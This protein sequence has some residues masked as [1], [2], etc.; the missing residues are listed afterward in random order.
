MTTTTLLESVLTPEVRAKLASGKVTLTELTK[1]VAHPEVFEVAT[2]PPLPAVISPAQRDALH[3]LELIYGS[4]CPAEVREL[5]TDE[6]DQLMDERL[7]ID[8]IATLVESRKSD[9]RTIVLNHVDAEN[10]DDEATPRDKEG[11]I[12]KASKTQPTQQKKVFSWE[13]SNRGG[14]IDVAALKE[15]D[16]S[17]ELAHEDYLAMTEQIRVVNE[18]RVL[19]L[20]KKKPELLDTLAKAVSKTSQ[21][22][23]LYV[24]KA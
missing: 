9:I 23:S 17:G 15:L 1:F 13:V 2:G 21:V 12:L 6:L 14:T 4:V 3:R 20:L 5:T 24:R 8:E 22:G 19:E 18:G 16:E 10:A 11:H 7:T